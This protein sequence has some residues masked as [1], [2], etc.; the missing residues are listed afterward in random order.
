MGSHY[1]HLDLSE[2]RLIEAGLAAGLSVAALA[3][4]LGRH[5]STVYREIARHF[6]HTAER[7]RWGHGYRGYYCVAA[8]R[9]AGRRRYGCAK[10]ARNPALLA[11]VLSKLR[12]G[13]SPEQIAGRLKV[14]PEVVGCVSHETIYRYVYSAEGRRDG[15]F[16][17]L[18]MARH[19]RRRLRGRKPRQGAIPPERWITARPASVADRSEFGHWECDL[20]LFARAFGEAN[21]TSLQERQSRYLILQANEDRRAGPLAASLSAL[22][23]SLPAPAR[24]TITFDR[25][26]EFM[27]YRAVP[28]DCYFCDPH[29]PWQKGGVENANGR[30]RRHLPLDSAPGDRSPGALSALCERLNATPRRCLNYRTPAEVF[31]AKLAELGAVG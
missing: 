13:W 24:Q 30:V 2:R 1:S 15:L 10:L 20:V 26:T 23:T 4:T 16:A 21:V 12:A 7:D 28:A 31:H 27:G 3:S 25:G 8:H 17:L 11:H 18:A 29:S 22:L 5:R 6:Y 14:E 19:R 9:A